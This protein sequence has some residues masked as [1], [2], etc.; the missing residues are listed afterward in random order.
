MSSDVGC[1]Q[2]E[3]DN[4]DTRM[5]KETLNG[6]YSKTGHYTHN[7]GLIDRES[8]SEGFNGLNIVSASRPANWDTDKDGMPDWWRKLMAPTQALP[9]TTATSM[10]TDILTLRNTSTGALTRISL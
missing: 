8:D 2:P 5:V 10:A 6:T 7:K 3:L 9:I 4:H 1:N